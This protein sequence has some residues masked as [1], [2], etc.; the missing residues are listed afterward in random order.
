MNRIDASLLRDVFRGEQNSEE[1]GGSS[2][3][4]EDPGTAPRR[5]DVWYLV[6]AACRRGACSRRIHSDA[7]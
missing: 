2:Q 6:V 4:T 7:L 3:A 5:S 1:D